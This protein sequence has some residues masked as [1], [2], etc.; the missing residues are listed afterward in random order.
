MA[1]NKSDFQNSNTG[2]L[3][4][5]NQAIEWVESQPLNVDDNFEVQDI[6]QDQINQEV[7]LDIDDNDMNNQIKIN[8]LRTQINNIDKAIENERL[9]ASKSNVTTK[10]S[11]RVILELN[12]L[13]TKK[14][15]KIK[16]LSTR[17]CSQFF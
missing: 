12:E 10:R 15:N 2:N 7:G 17:C 4:E 14:E 3:K 11:T 1:K 8:K 9:V 13:A 5:V 16:E 6:I